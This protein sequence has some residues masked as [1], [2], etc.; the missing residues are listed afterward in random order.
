M[1]VLLNTMMIR[2]DKLNDKQ[3]KQIKLGLEKDLDVS[4]YAKPEFDNRQMQEI[5]LGLEHKVD[6]SKYANTRFSW[7]QMQEIRLGLEN[8]L[9]VLKYAKPE[10]DWVQ[11]RM[12]K[13]ILLDLKNVGKLDLDNIL[14]IIIHADM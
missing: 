11:M 12:I 13:E 9:D 14:N 8:N 7:A 2:T 10:I 6:V 1:I 4:I 3:I 5:R